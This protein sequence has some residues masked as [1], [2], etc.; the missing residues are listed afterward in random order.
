[1][2]KVRNIWYNTKHVLK[3]FGLIVLAI[4]CISFSESKL[5]K[6]CCT[7]VIVTLQANTS[8]GDFL[9]VDDVY[10]FLDINRNMLIG[11]LVEDINVNKYEKALKDNPFVKS[12]DVYLSNTGEL[13]IT[14]QQRNPIVRIYT[15][16]NQF[17]I[18]EDGIEFPLSKRNS[19]RVL[20]ASGDF[21]VA[22]KSGSYV[23]S[24]AEQ[25]RQLKEIYALA[26]KISEDKMF[27]PMIE[28][29]YL[30]SLHQVMMVPKIGP[31]KIEVGKFD[32]DLDAKFNKLRAF[33]KADKVRENW[34]LYKSISLKFENQIVC[35]KK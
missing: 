16:K 35:T 14:I 6:Q 15:L 34:H 31:S 25:S 33:Y 8:H 4:V 5:K 32:R 27:A 24:D 22:C 20:V 1:M 23:L 17:Y 26:C 12:C 11:K 2:G 7:D 28:Q 21:D 9:T 18:D 13:H 10:D 29:I 30:D 19:S 3:P